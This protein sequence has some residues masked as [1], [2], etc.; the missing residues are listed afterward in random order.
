MAETPGSQCGVLGPMPGQGTSPYATARTLGQQIKRK[1]EP[2]QVKKKKGSGKVL[3][4]S[5]R[6]GS[7][8]AV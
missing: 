7:P 6:M 1:K 8:I 2:E 5:D 4:L 3:I